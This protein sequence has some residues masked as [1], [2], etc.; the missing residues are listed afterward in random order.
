M[1][2]DQDSFLYFL[3]F[4]FFISRK[5]KNDGC[6]LPRK[7]RLWRITLIST[8][9]CTQWAWPWGARASSQWGSA[10]FG[11]S[12]TSAL[13]APWPSRWW[14]AT[15]YT[16]TAAECPTKWR[17]SSLTLPQPTLS[18]TH[19]PAS[20]GSACS[21]GRPANERNE[22]VLKSWA[23]VQLFQLPSF[24]NT[25]IVSVLVKKIGRPFDSY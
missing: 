2:M 21:S 16:L 1:R 11:R 20:R 19:Q 3:Y 13:V 25:E 22:F 14:A 23:V 4:V 8:G 9:R 17:T 6:C 12:Q 15:P 10:L 18:G 24:R 7:A 5:E